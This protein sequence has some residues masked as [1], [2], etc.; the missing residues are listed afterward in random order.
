MRIGKNI[1][2]FRP[3]HKQLVLVKCSCSLQ[4]HSIFFFEA[5]LLQY[6]ILLH[7]FFRKKIKEELFLYP[8]L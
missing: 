6:T 7:I 4:G 3:T 1:L 2:N 8:S 5:K